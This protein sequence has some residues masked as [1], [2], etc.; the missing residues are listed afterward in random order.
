ML[1]LQAKHLGNLQTFWWLTLFWFRQKQLY[2]VSGYIHM[3]LRATLPVCFSKYFIE[4][5]NSPEF[6]IPNRFWNKRTLDALISLGIETENP[7]FSMAEAVIIDI[8]IQ[9]S[10]SLKLDINHR[11]PLRT[12]KLPLHGYFYSSLNPTY[13]EIFLV[14]KSNFHKSEILKYYV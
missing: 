14:R 5:M 7:P 10:Q 12:R 3:S 11:D 4:L 8:S 13:I 6:Q 2:Y 1:T 9:L